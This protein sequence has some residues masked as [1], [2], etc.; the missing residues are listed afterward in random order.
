[1]ATLNV[2]VPALG[3]GMSPRGPSTRPSCAEL[4]HL[5]RRRDEHVEVEPA[6]LDL[7]DVLDA[8]EIGAGVLRFARLVAGRDDEHAHRLAGAGRQHD[9]AA[10]DLIGVA[11][12]DARGGPRSRRS[13]RT[14]RMPIFLTISSACFGW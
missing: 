10:H 8:H 1:M 3:F 13:R 12:I 5:V 7:L 11:R 6:I 2:T 14:S 4:T 9:R